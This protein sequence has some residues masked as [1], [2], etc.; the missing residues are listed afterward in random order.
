MMGSMSLSLMM[1]RAAAPTGF[2]AASVSAT[3]TETSTTASSLDEE[4][5]SSMLSLEVDIAAGRVHSARLPLKL[6]VSCG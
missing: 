5:D 6:L 1:P 2:F 3:F 4:E